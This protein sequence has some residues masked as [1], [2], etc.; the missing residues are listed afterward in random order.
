MSLTCSGETCV[1]V[2]SDKLDQ[3]CLAQKL[4][5]GYQHHE[6]HGPKHQ[7]EASHGSPAAWA[8]YQHSVSGAAVRLM[9]AYWV[10]QHVQRSHVHQVKGL[11][12][13]WP[14]QSPMCCCWE[15]P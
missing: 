8:M 4:G 9:T 5:K 6:L 7:V 3:T 15:S 13:L 12:G 10:Q 11:Q 14:M 2:Y 1:A